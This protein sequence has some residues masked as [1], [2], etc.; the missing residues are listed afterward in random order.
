MKLK[1][2]D[3]VEYIPYLDIIDEDTKEKIWYSWHPDCDTPNGI[4]PE[5]WLNKTVCKFDYP[6]PYEELALFVKKEKV[7]ND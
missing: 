4:I 2:R 1:L 6:A 3:I 5:E 7:K